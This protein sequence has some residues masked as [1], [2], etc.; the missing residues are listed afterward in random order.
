MVYQDVFKYNEIETD[1]ELSDRSFLNTSFLY[2]DIVGPS[3]WKND[4]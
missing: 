2:L 4:L 3:Y 1:I